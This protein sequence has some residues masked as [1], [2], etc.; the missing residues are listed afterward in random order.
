MSRKAKARIIVN[1]GGGGNPMTK[2]YAAYRVSALVV[3]LALFFASDWMPL[4]VLQRD[5]I[6]WSVRV[7]GYNPISFI[8]EESPAI[9]VEGKIHFYTSAC[10]YV[11]LLVVVVPFVWVFGVSRRRNIMR[12]AIAALL[13]LSGNLVRCWAS[14]Y[15]DVLGIDRIY[16]HDLPNVAICCITVAAVVFSSCH[17]DWHI[18]R[19]LRS[20]APPV[21]SGG[22]A[23]DDRD[24]CERPV[25]LAGRRGA[26]EHG[27]VGN[28]YP[29]PDEVLLL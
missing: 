27:P 24:R 9:R 23:E 28:A 8:H 15:L 13:I 10:T 14:V 26:G 25:A 3:L 18:A 20:G 16:A 19:S 2:L 11:G 4:R 12:I 6:A 7:P 1:T 22:G 29:S 21:P 5:V 17:H